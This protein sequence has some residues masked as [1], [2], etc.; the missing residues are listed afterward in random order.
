M[1]SEHTLG[2]TPAQVKTVFSYFDTDGS[3]SIVF[4]EFLVGIRGNLNDRRRQLVL[5]AF[6]VSLERAVP[7]ILD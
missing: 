7:A 2:W 5:M 3:G 4:D 1:A 6:E